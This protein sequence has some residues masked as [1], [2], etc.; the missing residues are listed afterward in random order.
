MQFRPFCGHQVAP[1]RRS[2]QNSQD[3]R[4]IA[5]Q[6]IWAKLMSQ[7][8]ET[9]TVLNAVCFATISIRTGPFALSL[10]NSEV[11]RLPPVTAMLTLVA[12]SAQ[13]KL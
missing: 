5:G 6:Q 1:A 11:V 4:R 12:N 3:L 13:P 2:S 7:M 8:S 9:K 10:A